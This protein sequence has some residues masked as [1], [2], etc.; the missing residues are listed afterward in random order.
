MPLWVV[1]GHAAILAGL[2]L[3]SLRFLTVY[4]G[5]NLP[6]FNMTRGQ[7]A[8]FGLEAQHFFFGFLGTERR[9]PN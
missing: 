2:L 8:H 6:C 5:G 4:P 1:R 9:Y 7:R 3:T